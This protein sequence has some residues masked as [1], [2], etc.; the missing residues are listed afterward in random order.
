MKD[1]FIYDEDDN[2]VIGKVASTIMN[3]LGICLIRI[4]SNNAQYY[5]KLS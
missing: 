4:K 5:K 2:T 1:K 3:N